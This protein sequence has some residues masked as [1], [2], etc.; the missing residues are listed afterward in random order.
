MKKQLIRPPKHIIDFEF[1][2][3]FL[4]KLQKKLHRQS[5]RLTTNMGQK[6]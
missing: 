3:D 2:P 6:L 5:Y 1:N 4:I